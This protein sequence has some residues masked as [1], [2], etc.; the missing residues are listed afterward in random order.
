MA[1]DILVIIFILSGLF[2]F[3]Q[4]DSPIRNYII[5]LQFHLLAC[6]TVGSVKAYTLFYN[7]LVH[8]GYRDLNTIHR[9]SYSAEYHILRRTE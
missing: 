2:I 4:W 8:L 3:D 1:E 7:E 5:N 6:I 9:L